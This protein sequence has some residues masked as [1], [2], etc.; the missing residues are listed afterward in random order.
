MLVSQSPFELGP[1]VQCSVGSNG[2]D[3]KRLALRSPG[4]TIPTVQGS[5]PGLGK[6]IHHCF[7][8]FIYVIFF[9]FEFAHKLHYPARAWSGILKTLWVK[10]F[11]FISYGAR[12]VPYTVK[13][14]ILHVCRRLWNYQQCVWWFY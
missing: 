10:V 11:T 4:P 9:S 3:L 2:M 14:R 12:T 1:L 13:G 5:L 8:F 6:I 7:Q